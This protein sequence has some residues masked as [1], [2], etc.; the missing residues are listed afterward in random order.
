MT[1]LWA[2]LGLLLGAAAG[3]AIGLQIRRGRDQELMAEAEREAES[4][5]QS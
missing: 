5:T 2:I 4:D 3:V 1:W